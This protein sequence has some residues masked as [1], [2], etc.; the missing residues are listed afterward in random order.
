ML[1]SPTGLKLTTSKL[2]RFRNRG[3]LRA[4]DDR[5]PISGLRP[6][7]PGLLFGLVLRVERCLIL[8]EPMNRLVVRPSIFS[9]VR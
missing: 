5:R 1:R 2:H 3:C 9:H 7:L 8:G 4:F 6:T